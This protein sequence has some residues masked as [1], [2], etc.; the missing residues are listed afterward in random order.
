MLKKTLTYDD[1]DEN[2]ITDDF[3]FH[4]NKLEIMKM[5]LEFDGAS[6]LEEIMKKLTETDNAREAYGL[7]E[8]VLLSAY[9]VKGADNKTFIKSPELTQAFAQSSALGELIF[10]MLENPKDA[11]LFIEQVLPSKLVA[12]AKVE[13]SKQ[14]D[15]PKLSLA[16]VQAMRGE[17]I[18]EIVPKKPQ[19]MTREELLEAMR[20]KSQGQ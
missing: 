17:T 10:E 7:F 4:L 5:S 11:A 15:K 3:Y 20:E 1:L 16:E 8:K 18:T 9:G 14:E 12:E 13:E 19:D 2:T 6:G